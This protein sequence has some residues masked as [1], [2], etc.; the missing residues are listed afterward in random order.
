MTVEMIGRDVEE[1]AD[2]GTKFLNDFELKTADFDDGDG[3][4]AGFGNARDQ[5]RAD[6]AR[7]NRGN[8]RA[9]KD[10]TD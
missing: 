5:R 4:I 10:V 9:F 6:I 3:G 2:L 8:A 7:N 1:H